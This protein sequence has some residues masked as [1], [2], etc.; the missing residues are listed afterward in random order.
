MKWTKSDWKELMFASSLEYSFLRIII[1]IEERKKQ[2]EKVADLRTGIGGIM[3]FYEDNKA[4]IR[5]FI[6]ERE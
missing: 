1:N 3:S 4:M 5:N 6:S 2:D